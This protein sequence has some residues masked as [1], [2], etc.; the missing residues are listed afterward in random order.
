MNKYYIPEINLRDIR[1]SYNIIFNKIKNKTNSKI[2][3]DRIIISNDG[4]YKYEDENLIKYNSYQ[5]N[6]NIKENFL[7]KYTLIGI[8]QYDKKIGETYNIPYE[9]NYV[10]I[11]KSM[12]CFGKSKNFLV[13]EKKNN[14]IIDIYFLSDKKIDEN[15]MFFN[16]DISLFIEMLIC[17]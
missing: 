8:K 12:F 7:K 1:N 2:Y 3:K 6:F 4:Y 15:N 5:N 10:D 13:F 16:K 17:K 11:E 9:S 14:K